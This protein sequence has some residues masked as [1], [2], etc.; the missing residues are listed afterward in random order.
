MWSND[1]VCLLYT[2]KTQSDDKFCLEA[3]ENV[4]FGSDFRIPPGLLLRVSLKVRDTSEPGSLKAY[5]A[6]DK[7]NFVPLSTEATQ[8]HFSDPKYPMVLLLGTSR[9]SPLSYTKPCAI[10]CFLNGLQ[11]KDPSIPLVRGVQ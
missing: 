4:R 1:K 9:N 10:F 5:F 7:F 11:M 3:N 2:C 8:R 6:P